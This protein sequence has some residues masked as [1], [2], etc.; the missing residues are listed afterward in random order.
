MADSTSPAP[1]PW[2]ADI[3]AGRADAAAGRTHD[4][5]AV[6]AEFEREDRADKPAPAAPR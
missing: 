6:I 3:E 5:A 4:L 2:L 1:L